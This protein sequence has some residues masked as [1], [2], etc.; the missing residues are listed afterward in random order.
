MYSNAICLTNDKVHKKV[1]KWGFNVVDVAIR[2]K[3]SIPLTSKTSS[4][5]V[6][7]FRKSMMTQIFFLPGQCDGGREF[8][9]QSSK[10]MRRP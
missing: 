3:Y 1:F 4:E 2:Y 9:G 5:V 7:A 10:L 8:M 6:K